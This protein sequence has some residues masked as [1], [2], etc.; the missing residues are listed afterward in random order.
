MIRIHKA[1]NPRHCCTSSDVL[2]PVEQSAQ[3]QDRQQVQSKQTESKSRPMRWGDVE[4][5]KTV[6]LESIRGKSWDA[7]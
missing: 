5:I 7:K 4:H 6:L 1:P 3:Y 2:T